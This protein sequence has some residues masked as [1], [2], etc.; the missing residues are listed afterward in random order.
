MLV[1]LLGF[2]VALEESPEHPH[3]AHPDDLLWHTGVGGTLPLSSSSM[4]P[5]PASNGVLPASGTGV[6]SYGFSD[7]QTIL[8]QLADV[9]PC[10][11]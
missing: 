11:K 5:L 9:L 6:H 8:N 4:T 10:S 3:T 2:P 7:D 1:D